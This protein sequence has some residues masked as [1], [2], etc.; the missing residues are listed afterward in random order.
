MNGQA[1]LGLFQEHGEATLLQGGGGAELGQPG[2]C[3]CL[4]GA[5]LFLQRIHLLLLF[6]ERGDFGTASGEL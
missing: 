5:E 4:R 3:I 2:G 1:A 6:A